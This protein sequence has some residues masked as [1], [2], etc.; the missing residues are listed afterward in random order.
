M[1][2][3]NS[4][5]SKKIIIVVP[6]YNEEESIGKVIDT[7]PK[8]KGFTE[9]EVELVCAN[10]VRAF[11][12]GKRILRTETAPIVAAAVILYESGQMS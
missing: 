12:L 6:A 2:S 3:L 10:G 5:K 1:D 11:S 9:Q 4:T 8:V 7:L